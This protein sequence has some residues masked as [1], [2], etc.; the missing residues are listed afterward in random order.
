MARAPTGYNQCLT[1]VETAAGREV[2]EDELERIFSQLQGKARRYQAAGMT[3]TEAFVRAGRELGDE[4]RLAGAIE[5]RNKL[6]NVARR[7]EIMRRLGNS[8]EQ[9]KLRVLLRET[10]QKQHGL[11]MEL[12]GPFVADLQKIGADKAL[13]RGDAAFERA[14]WK[15]LEAI[16]KKQGRA[17]TN[18]LAHAT[19]KIIADF[20]ERARTMQNSAGAWIGKREDYITRQIHDQDKVRGTGDEAAFAAWRDFI[21]PKLDE[22]T[23]DTLDT[24][25][26]K[27]V[28][29]FMRAV[30]KALASGVHDRPNG[31]VEWGDVGTGTG[32]GNLAKRASATRTLVFKDADGRADY[33][34]AFGRG[35]LMNTV[36]ASLENAARNT[37]VMQVWGPNPAAMFDT[38][39]GDAQKRARDRLD[40]KQVDALNNRMNAP[41]VKTLLGELQADARQSVFGAG[42]PVPSWARQL[43]WSH[44]GTWASA[45]QTVSKLGGVVLSSFAD[46]ANNAA[47]LRHNGVPL[48]ES[49]GNQIRAIMPQGPVR[50]EI[51]TL[52]GASVDSVL[53]QVAARHDAMPMGTGTAAK[54]VEVFHRLNLLQW[55]TER[56]KTGVG[57]ML[58]HNLGRSSTLDFA[59]L[60]PLLQATMRRYGITDA[61]WTAARRVT[62]KAGDGREYLMPSEITDPA[63]RSKFYAY[64]TDQV[65]DAMNE[66]DAYVRTLMTAGTQN[67]TALGTAVRLITQFKTYPVTF[68]RRVYLREMEG[69][70]DAGGLA[71]L[72][73]ATT[74]LGYLSMEAKQLARG[75][76]TRAS[77]IEGPGGAAK[78][79]FSAMLQ[80][81]GFGL[82]G[83]FLFGDVTRM[84]TGPVVSMLGPTVGTLDDFTKL[85][86]TARKAFFEGDAQSAR[87]MQSQG[88]GFIRD[89][90]PFANL[91]YAR[92]AL[93]H[94]VWFR[95]QEALNPGYLSRYEQ[96]MKRENDTTFWLS[97]S[98]NPY[99][100]AGITQ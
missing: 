74:F 65:R 60:D 29:D 24:L 73:V 72:L 16:G 34:A 25:D 57:T 40:M 69:G 46:V 55:W 82:Y 96:R 27:S 4:M 8:G 9:A 79:M 90:T 100:A 99:R 42:A 32:P 33:H 56:M 30:W 53:G 7:N 85:V 41:Y 17:S 19:A 21:L 15:E 93:D 2:K 67:G 37:G 76:D 86:L 1:A 5:K 64:L 81:G 98:A 70:A 84:G 83:D 31:R 94:L 45:L 54:M 92:A 26:P 59:A 80:G 47:V 68:M 11:S 13:A 22:A 89:N 88:L 63:L 66:P 49:Y 3:E 23:F 77:N 61:D 44:V 97:P 20:Q 28:N 39:V 58:A 6:I 91:F 14:V 50:K 10:D 12:L 48:L 18:D 87:D 51:G 71:H 36:T 62:K 38:I 78:T 75:R 95:L 52:L 35:N 43:T